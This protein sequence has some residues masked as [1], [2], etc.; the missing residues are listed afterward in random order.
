VP[1]KVE[2]LSLKPG[3][4]NI[5]VNWKEPILNSYC[6][7]NYNIYWVNTLS[8]SSDTSSVSSEEYSFIIEHLGACEGYEVSV[9]AVSE[10]EEGTD[11]TGK[12]A[13]QT[14]C[15]SHTHNAYYIYILVAIMMLVNI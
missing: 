3:S 4:N 10:K 2:E 7:T 9:T 11:V 1:G 12:M 13:T 6:V 5:T 8:G 14:T 15:N